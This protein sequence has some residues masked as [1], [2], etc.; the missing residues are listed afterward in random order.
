MRQRIGSGTIWQNSVLTDLPVVSKLLMEETGITSLVDSDPFTPLSEFTPVFNSSQLRA[1]ISNASSRNIVIMSSL[2]LSAKGSIQVLKSLNIIGR[3]LRPVAL[4]FGG[5]SSLIFLSAS[6]SLK[7]AYLTLM[8]LGPMSN[9]SALPA[10]ESSSHLL[11]NLTSGLWAF[12]F[13]R[14]LSALSVSSCI[15]QVSYGE[16]LAL[17]S[18]TQRA[19]SNNDSLLAN[20][21]QEALSS[22]AS[23]KWISPVS[24]AA[25]ALLSS[26]ISS[27][28]IDVIS[29]SNG[30]ISLR[31]LS[32]L[33]IV[34]RS[35]T[36][37]SP[38]HP[39]LYI[40][41]SD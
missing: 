22:N 37:F 29:A 25:S 30:T 7:L 11:A 26:Y 2:S 24:P 20:Q 4:D 34:A 8:G 21:L 38:I 28:S 18:L 32:I 1:Q 23:A 19:L 31:T 15:L 3:R 17:Q 33:G 14:F 27:A 10:L 5:A 9:T 6:V 36:F 39:E 12:S 41:I 13:S 40:Q 35:H 16:V